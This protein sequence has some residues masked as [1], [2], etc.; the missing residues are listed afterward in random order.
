MIK[1]DTMKEEKNT[2]KKQDTVPECTTK[3][4][5]LEG[6][7]ANSAK[8]QSYKNPFWGNEVEL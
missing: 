2:Y 6:V 8:P 3:K 5:Q 1:T 4:V 7:I